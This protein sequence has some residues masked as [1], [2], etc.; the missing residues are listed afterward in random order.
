VRRRLAHGDGPRQ[1]A[2]AVAGE[3]GVAR[4]TIYETALRLRAEERVP[5][6]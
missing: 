4:R 5:P 3:L 2:A 1:A 6:A